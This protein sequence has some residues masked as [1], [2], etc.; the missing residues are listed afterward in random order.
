MNIIIINQY[1]IYY[2]IAIDTMHWGVM[3]RVVKTFGFLGKNHT[4]PPRNVVN[5]TLPTSE[6][7]TL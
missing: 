1:N 3:N 4:V 2:T 5:I 7:C 6:C